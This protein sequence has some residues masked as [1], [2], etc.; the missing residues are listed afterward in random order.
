MARIFNTYGPRMA[1]FVVL[2]FLRK[3]RDNPDCLEILGSGR[4]VRDFTYVD[5]TVEGLMTLAAAGSPGEAYN[6]SSG[7]RCNVTELAHRILRLQGITG[8]TEI[9]YTG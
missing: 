1:R 5:D 9:V 3:L 8:H 7:V 2:D 4:Q 6:I